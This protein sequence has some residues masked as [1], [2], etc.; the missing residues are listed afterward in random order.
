[1]LG[2]EPLPYLTEKQ[3]FFGIDFKV[4][5]DVLIPRPETELLVEFALDWLQKKKNKTLIADVGTGS[6]CIAVALGK[7]LSSAGIIGTDF[8]FDALQIAKDNIDR[9]ALENQI[10]LVQTDLLAGLTVKFD[11]ICA[12]LPYIPTKTL[13]TLKVGNFEPWDAL[14]GGED[15]LRFIK[16]LLNQ[17]KK[18]IKPDGLILLEIESSLSHF[19][20]ELAAVVFPDS[21]IKIHNDL[22]RLPRLVQIQLEGE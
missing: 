21:S 16:P 7:H 15:G 22:A 19:V 10:N 6:G 1:L 11:C 20:F 3:E 4:T 13:S 18:C 17:S 14:D 12:N 5:P 8:S 2:G 9:Q